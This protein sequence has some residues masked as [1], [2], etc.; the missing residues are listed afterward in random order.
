MRGGD[1]RERQQR[2]YHRG[3]INVNNFAAM[4][5]VVFLIVDAAVLATL[6]SGVGR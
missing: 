5:F 1:R 3:N 4:H 6:F 2:V